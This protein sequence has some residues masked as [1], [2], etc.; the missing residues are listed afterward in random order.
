MED[1]ICEFHKEP[2]IRI[3]LEDGYVYICPDRHCHNVKGG[4]D[5]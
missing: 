5:N 3:D 1:K 2:M 4:R